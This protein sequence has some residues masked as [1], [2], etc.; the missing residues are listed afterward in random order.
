M[1][2][3]VGVQSR[4]IWQVITGSLSASP[5]LAG[6]CKTPQFKIFQLGTVALLLLLL[7]HVCGTIILWRR[8]LTRYLSGPANVSSVPAAIIMRGLNRNTTCIR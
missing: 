4:A 2:R 8:G 1:A 6:Q 5:S 3:A 7:Y